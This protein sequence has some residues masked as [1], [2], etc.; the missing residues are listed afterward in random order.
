MSTPSGRL[1]PGRFFL[2]RRPAAA[3]LR[4]PK[5]YS[6]GFRVVRVPA[7][8]V[9]N[10]AHAIP[11]HLR[12]ATSPRTN[13]YGRHTIPLFVFRVRELRSNLAGDT[14]LESLS[15]RRRAAA[16]PGAFRGCYRIERRGR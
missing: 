14:R 12:Q 10:A 15:S 2:W 9:G 1:P 6:G 13:A 11:Q 5:S 7:F 8:F 16:T 3:G 4:S